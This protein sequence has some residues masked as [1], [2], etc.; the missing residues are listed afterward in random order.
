MQV[1]I[2]DILTPETTVTVNVASEPVFI[3]LGQYH[4]AVG[5]N[6]RVW[7]YSLAEGKMQVNK[8][9]KISKIII[10]KFKIKALYL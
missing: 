3:A 1:T 8:S 4:F 2:T 6:N 10:L 9:L 5:M 7:I